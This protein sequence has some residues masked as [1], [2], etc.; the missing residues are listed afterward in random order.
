[1]RFLQVTEAQMY[2][3][4]LGWSLLSGLF[5]FLKNFILVALVVIGVY[6]KL[7]ASSIAANAATL[8]AR[9]LTTT[10]NSIVQPLKEIIV[11]DHSDGF[12]WSRREDYL[13]FLAFINNIRSLA[14]SEKAVIELLEV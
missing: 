9:V 13:M 12:E 1:M 5:F 14:S 6:S 10:T 4:G 2:G 7:Q 8:I 11:I 3:R